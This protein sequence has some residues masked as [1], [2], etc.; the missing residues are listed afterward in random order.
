M[1]DAQGKQIGIL[2]RDEALLKAKNEG[3]DVVEI[4]ANANPPVAKIVDFQ[5]FRYEENKRDRAAK[6]GATEGGMKE[7]W[8]SP[9]IAEHD[10]GVRLNQANKFFEAGHK[11]KLTV[12]F[13][14]RELGHRELGYKVLNEALAIL[15]ERV[16]ADREPKFEGRKLSVVL[17]KT[18][19]V[20]KD[21]TENKEVNTEKDQNN[22]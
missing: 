19:G 2:T 1:L 11:V 6:K 5:K 22:I 12:K 13:K 9:R 16:S 10:L 20:K 3:L 17:T 15:G 18:K 7:L 4:A 14:G 21:E 8:L